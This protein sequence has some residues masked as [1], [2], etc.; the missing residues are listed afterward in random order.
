M[1]EDLHMRL[2]KQ[3][4]LTVLSRTVVVRSRGR[5]PSWWSRDRGGPCN[6]GSKR[7]L[8]HIQLTSLRWCKR[9]THG[10]TKVVFSSIGHLYLKEKLGFFAISIVWASFS[11]TSMFL[12]HGVENRDD[13][14]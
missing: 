4:S 6:R 13:I 1:G 5:S 2:D 3:L 10:T 14:C 11:T 9:G 7:E 8:A 12:F